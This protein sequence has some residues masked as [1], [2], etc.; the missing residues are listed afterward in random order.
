MPLSCVDI[1]NLSYFA[2]VYP[3]LTLLRFLFLSRFVRVRLDTR[4]P[5]AALLCSIVSADLTSTPTWATRSR[6]GNGHNSSH[7]PCWC[8][9]RFAQLR[10]SLRFRCRAD[11]DD[12]LL[13]SPPSYPTDFSR[14]S[15]HY[16]FSTTRYVW[17]HE[18]NRHPFTSSSL[19]HESCPQPSLFAPSRRS[20]RCACRGCRA[21]RHRSFVIKRRGLHAP[22]YAP[23][24]AVASRDCILVSLSSSYHRRHQDRERFL[25]MFIVSSHQY[26]RSRAELCKRGYC[27]PVLELALMLYCTTL[28]VCCTHVSKAGHCYTCSY[29]F[30]LFFARGCLYCQIT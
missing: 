10:S 16:L 13:S 5:R 30:N 17:M 3:I 24:I 28:R 14:R 6:P 15:V 1:V 11:A 25:L 2:F 9:R 19:C 12:Q 8:F 22:S 18:I 26:N 7:S 4:R 21:A 29:D 23:A 20:F 27:Y